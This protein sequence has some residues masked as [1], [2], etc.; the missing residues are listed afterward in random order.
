GQVVGG[1]VST[2]GDDRSCFAGEGPLPRYF[3]YATKKD[4]KGTNFDIYVA[5]KNLESSVWSA[6]T[7]I[8]PITTEQDELHPWITSD[9]KSLYFS[10]G[11]DEGWRVFGTRRRRGGIAQGFGEPALVKELPPDFH[12]V[13]LTPDGKTMFLQGPLDDGR[14]GLFVSAR[15]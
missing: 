11:A 5:V 12:H 3:Y 1:Y 10:R 7:P 13:T 8:N 2:A 6:P 14:T 15:T 4:K 9:G